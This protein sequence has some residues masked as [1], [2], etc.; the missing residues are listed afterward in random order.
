MLTN[1]QILPGTTLG[2]VIVAGNAHH[3]SRIDLED[4]HTALTTMIAAQVAHAAEV[5]AL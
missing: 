3:I 4:H 1:D 2:K 5:Q